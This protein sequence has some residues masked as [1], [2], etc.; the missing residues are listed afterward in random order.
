MGLTL[1]LEDGADAVQG[2]VEPAFI[3]EAEIEFPVFQSIH[4]V[5]HLF[6]VLAAGMH[7]SGCR[8]DDGDCENQRYDLIQRHIGKIFRFAQNG[9]RDCSE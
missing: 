9:N 3:L 4:H 7:G 6:D 1:L 8:R 2:A 5:V